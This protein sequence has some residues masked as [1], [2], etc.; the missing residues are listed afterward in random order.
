M[1][2]SLVPELGREDAEPLP[3]QS[4]ANQ[5]RSEVAAAGKKQLVISSEY[6]SL[7]DSCSKLLDW[8]T[9][10]EFSDPGDSTALVVVR[11]PILRASSLYNQRVKDPLVGETRSPDDFLHQEAKKQCY[12]SIIQNL[13]RHHISTQIIAYEPSSSLVERVLLAAGATTDEIPETSQ[14]RNVSLA[15]HVLVAMLAVNRVVPEIQRRRMYF[16]AISKARPA[17]QP[18]NNI[19]SSQATAWALSVFQRDLAIPSLTAGMKSGASQSEKVSQHNKTE[20]DE[21]FLLLTEG[22]RML[23]ENAVRTS[24]LDWKNVSKEIDVLAGISRNRNQ[25]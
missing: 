15:K 11:D 18:A 25:L 7:G 23:I 6:L 19:F 20:P 2:F 8:L 13:M 22:E 10:H 16:A 21:D 1:I 17:F 4:I 24:G 12:S 3:E 5:L 14:R 9:A